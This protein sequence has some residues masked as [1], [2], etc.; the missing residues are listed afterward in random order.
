M[1]FWGFCGTEPF[2]MLVFKVVGDDK[3]YKFNYCSDDGFCRLCELEE[4]FEKQLAKVEWLP[5]SLNQ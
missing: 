2:T 3:I 1:K 4:G 5:H